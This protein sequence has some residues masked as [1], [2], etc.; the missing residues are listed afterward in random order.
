MRNRSGSENLI[1]ASDWLLPLATSLSLPR[2]MSC[3][4]IRALISDYSHTQWFL[5]ARFGIITDVL[6]GNQR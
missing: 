4:R 6:G 1:A 3:S 2:H 5:V